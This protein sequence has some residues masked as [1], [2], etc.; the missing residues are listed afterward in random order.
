MVQ[1]G[2]PCLG[3]IP[4]ECRT[5]TPT[6]ASGRR[7]WEADGGAKQVWANRAET[8]EQLKPDVPHL[9]GTDNIPVKSTRNIDVTFRTKVMMG[10]YR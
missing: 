7:T 9:A 8:N 1:S 10:E 2:S 6:Q 4:A 3:Q 5:I